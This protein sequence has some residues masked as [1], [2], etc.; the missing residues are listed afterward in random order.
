MLRLRGG[1]H[2][3]CHRCDYDRPHREQQDVL[4]RLSRRLSSSESSSCIHS[5]NIIIQVSDLQCCFAQ[6]SKGHSASGQR[7][8]VEQRHRDKVVTA[9][10]I[11]VPVFQQLDVKADYV[12]KKYKKDILPEQAIYVD[13]E[14][15]RL[16]EGNAAHNVVDGPCLIP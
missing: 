15:E 6:W 11:S 14:M 16:N 12:K 13:S 7:E 8:A 10:P 4:Q 5:G 9:E 3:W 2:Q 1:R